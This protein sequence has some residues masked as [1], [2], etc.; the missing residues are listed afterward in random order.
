[1]SLPTQRRQEIAIQS[2]FPV[3]LV[4]LDATMAVQV[5]PCFVDALRQAHR[6]PVGDFIL[7]VYALVTEWITRG[8]Y[9]AW[10]PLAAAVAASVL[11]Y[12]PRMETIRIIRADQSRMGQTAL[13][14]TGTKVLVAEDVTSGDYYRWFWQEATG[15]SLPP[16]VQHCS[17]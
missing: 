7:S 11:P 10:D 3:T 2:Q 12:D 6:R 17:E 1:M 13:D 8:D 14:S 15:F 5:T 9:Y 4:P 16:A